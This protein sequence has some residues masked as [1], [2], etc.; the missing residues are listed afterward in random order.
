MLPR[1]KKMKY[2]LLYISCFHFILLHV[3]THKIHIYGD[4]FF[5]ER[6]LQFGIYNFVN[7]WICFT[8]FSLN[9]RN[10]GN[11]LGAESSIAARYRIH[12]V[13]KTVIVTTYAP[14]TNN[15]ICGILDTSDTFFVF[16]VS[17]VSY[18]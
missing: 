13:I 14:G 6:V 1:I 15:H 12:Q 4:I 17:L 11:A 5:L 3:I 7:L 18:C 10:F 16:F 9:N 2:T 8:R